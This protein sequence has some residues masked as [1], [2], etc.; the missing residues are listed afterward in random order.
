MVKEKWSSLMGYLN[1]FQTYS[2]LIK[3]V[4]NMSCSEVNID[5][6]R[7][8]ILKKSVSI[9]RIDCRI[10]NTMRNFLEKNVHHHCYLMEALQKDV[11][12]FLVTCLAREFY[13]NNNKKCMVTCSKILLNNKYFHT[14]LS[15]VVL[16]AKCT[17]GSRN[18]ER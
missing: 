14:F 7:V 1:I 10:V 15:L 3:C 12:V 17:S 8:W 11:L 4:L 2:Q 13:K 6:I 16:H 18:L 9:E 5:V